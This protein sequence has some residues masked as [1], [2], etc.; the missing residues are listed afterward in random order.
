MYVIKYKDYGFWVRPT[1]L[2]ASGTFK[3][4]EDAY[5]VAEEQG[6]MYG[7][8]YRVFP[9]EEKYKVEVNFFNG[10]KWNPSGNKGLYRMAFASK[11]EAEQAIKM[12]GSTT[13]KYR[14]VPILESEPMPEPEEKLMPKPEFVVVDKNTPKEVSVPR[15]YLRASQNIGLLCF[16]ID[17][18]PGF[19]NSYYLAYI[20]AN[21][22]GNL[23]LKTCSGLSKRLPVRFA[24]LRNK[25]MACETFDLDRSIAVEVE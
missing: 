5:K 24:D 12:Y 3:R 6:R 15:F 8:F 11:A 19:E 22:E 16:E 14:A 25:K 18:D 17:S 1:N 23:V 4:L 9:L 10:D 20:E 7:R 21:P 13:M 2:G